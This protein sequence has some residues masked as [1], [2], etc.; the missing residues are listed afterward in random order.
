MKLMHLKC[1]TDGM[2]KGPILLCE[3]QERKLK[4]QKENQKNSR[5]AIKISRKGNIGCFLKTYHNEA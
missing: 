1:L 2:P 4:G 5:H 3:Y